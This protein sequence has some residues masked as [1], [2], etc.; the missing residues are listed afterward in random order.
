M[1][2]VPKQRASRSLLLKDGGSHHTLA[3]SLLLSDERGDLEAKTDLL[4]ADWC[5]QKV[6]GLL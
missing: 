3:V 1:H 2:S 5:P 4:S 6:L